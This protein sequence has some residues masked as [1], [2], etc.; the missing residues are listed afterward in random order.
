MGNNK[1]NNRSTLSGADDGSNDVGC[2]NNRVRSRYEIG[3]GDSNGF[4]GVNRSQ[5]RFRDVHH[6]DMAHILNYWIN[7]EKF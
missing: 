3:Y 4:G 7:R 6:N 5:H 1:S 2:K